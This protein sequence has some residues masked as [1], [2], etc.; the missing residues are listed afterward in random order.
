[1]GQD[2]EARV[3][4]DG[5]EFAGRAYLESEELLVR[6]ERRLKIPLAEVS[7][8]AAGNGALRLAWQGHAVELDVG[9]VAER[10]AEKIRN[11]KTL[12]DKLGVKPGMR[13]AVA[14]LDDARFEA[15]LR[16][17]GATLCAWDEPDLDAVFQSVDDVRGLAVLAELRSRIAPAGAIWILH[18]KGRRDIRDVDV[19]A[20]AKA[21]GLVDT[22]VAKFSETR[23]ALKLVIP[24]NQR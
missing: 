11:P 10:W 13:V 2:V 6:G 8:L 1:M 20:A 24:V 3:R 9:P 18:P 21:A 7:S 4:I 12:L 16:A 17:K 23:S 22:K 15:D 19:M 5:E 14:G